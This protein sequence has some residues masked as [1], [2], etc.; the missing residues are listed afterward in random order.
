MKVSVIVGYFNRESV[1]ERTIESLLAQTCADMEIIAFDDCSTDGT[2]DALAAFEAR[3]N[4]PRLRVIRH[5]K[6]IGFVQGL[7]NAV[8]VASGEYIAIHG[9][10]DVAYPRRIELLAAQLDSDS[11]LSVVGSWYENVNDSTGSRSIVRTRAEDATLDSLMRKNV[12]S[13]GEVM[14]RRDAYARAG[15]YRSE[16]TFAQ[17]IDLWMR[18]RKEGRFSTVPE[19]LYERHILSDGVTH[20]PNKAARQARFSILARRLSLMAPTEVDE[21]LARVRN[22]G[23][24][25]VI[26]LE[27]EDLQRRIRAGIVDI[28]I[29]GTPRAAVQVARDYLIGSASR[30]LYVSFLTV[31]GS[32]VLGAALQWTAMWLI[33]ARRKIRT[34]RASR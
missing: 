15:G 16:F 12:Y 26:P 32:P 4:S 18:M 11:E 9:S 17:D 3:E 19:L 30:N 25:S 31:Y 8:D 21:T 24:E 28:A 20:N 23:P 7:I 2:G 29:S 1:V 14:F 10:G 27:D 13:H 33:K 5:H 22:D 34:A 6:N